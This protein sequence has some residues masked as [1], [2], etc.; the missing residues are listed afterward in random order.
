MYIT[1]V[2]QMYIVKNCRLYRPMYSPWKLPSAQYSKN[3]SLII[4]RQI[5]GCRNARA[6]QN[7]ATS[8]SQL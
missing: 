6:T 8:H 4:I 5:I 3:K 2:I 7:Q 1:I